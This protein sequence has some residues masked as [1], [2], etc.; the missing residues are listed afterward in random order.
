MNKDSITRL[1]HV[2]LPLVLLIPNKTQGAIADHPLSVN[3]SVQPNIFFMLDDSGSMSYSVIHANEAEAEYPALAKSQK[4]RWW[5]NELHAFPYP[6]PDNQGAILKTCAGYNHLYFNNNVIYTPWL[7]KDKEGIAFDDQ[8]ITAARENPYDPTETTDLTQAYIGSYYN[9]GISLPSVNL[10][11]GYSEWDDKDGDGVFDKGECPDPTLPGYDYERDFIT[12]DKMTPEERTNFANWYTYYRKRGNILKK[13]MLPI[14]DNS[15]ARMGLS[16]LNLRGIEGYPVADMRDQ[17]NREQ[18]K[19][20][21]LKNYYSG[22]TALRHKLDQVGQYFENKQPAGLFSTPQVS[23][24]LPAEKGGECQKNFAILM[25]DGAWTSTVAPAIGNADS[26]N[27]SAYDGGSYADKEPGQ[28]GTLADVAMHY[29]ERDLMP[30]L[31]DKVHISPRDTNKQQHMVTYTVAFGVNGTLDR[32]PGPDEDSFPWPTPVRLQDTTI[33]DMR[34]A[35][36]NG[37]GEFLSA[38]SPDALEAALNGAIKSIIARTSSSASVATNSSR[39]NSHSKLY[40]VRFNTS[41]WSGELLAYR[42]NPETGAPDGFLWNSAELIPAAHLRKIYTSDQPRAGGVE[43]SWEEAAATLAAAGLDEAAVH[44]LRGDSSLE[45]SLYRSRGSRLGDIVNSRPVYTT[46]ESV[47]YFALETEA[48][49]STYDDYLAGGDA[50]KGEKGGRPAMIYVGANDGMLHGFL[51]DGEMGP[52]CNPDTQACEGKELFSY[53]PRALHDQLHQLPDPD[54]NH[55]FYVNNSAVIGD[56]F[57]PFEGAAN[58]SGGRWGSALVGTLGAGGK[59][60][61][62]LDVSNP[63][64]FAEEDILWDYTAADTDPNG[65][66]FADLGYT[67]ARPAVVKLK[68]DGGTGNNDWGVI[69]GNGYSS[70]HGKAVLYIIGLKTGEI[71][72]QKEVGAAGSNGLSTPVAIDSNRDSIADIIYAGDLN[73]NLWKFDVSSDDPRQ[74]DVAFKQAGKAVPLFKACS[75]SPCLKPQPITTKPLV[76]RAKSGGLMVLFG[77]GQ[78][79]AEGDNTDTSQ[80]QSYYGIQDLGK[81]PVER[82]DLQHQE[83]TYEALASD[84][85]YTDDARALSNYPVNYNSKRGWYLDFNSLNYPGE[86]VV[87]DALLYDEVVHLNTLV[88][89][90]SICEFGGKSWSFAFEPQTGKVIERGVFDLNGDGRIDKNDWLDTDADGV[91]DQ[92]SSAVKNQAGLMDSP[93]ILDTEGSGKSYNSDEEGNVPLRDVAGGVRLGR[94]SWLQIR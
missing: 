75:G 61:F 27:S 89:N 43:F 86:R 3:V 67:F 47:G 59:G 46:D 69:L 53:I 4:D 44:Y 28:S 10:K 37:R 68:S 74:W 56:A 51:A 13:V 35:A 41:D 29:Y 24:I 6:L 73:G 2:V 9:D 18:I 72:W 70:T 78:Y 42:L 83:I 39:L 23:P 87:A 36:W 20:G 71:I 85:G 62:A 45:G 34:H 66:S 92:A 14:V 60:V 1:S 76:I 40:Q 54:Y 7:G 50:D 19:E 22:G 26:D 90:T 8:S 17:S 16:T 55:R 94:Q 5:A 25:S 32:N 79:F 65:K 31:D 91:K 77:T 64:A 84:T 57:I 15:R 33:D 48:G 21:I 11:R 58:E 49:L 80:V 12:V 93:V 52:D 81:T 38:R 82:S 88:P 63:E 30:G